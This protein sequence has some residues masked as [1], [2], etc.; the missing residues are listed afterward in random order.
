MKRKSQ[1]AECTTGW[2]YG[3]VSEG[4]QGLSS[5]CLQEGRPIG[6]TP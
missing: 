5:N 4:G 2:R 3:R 1:G 6:L